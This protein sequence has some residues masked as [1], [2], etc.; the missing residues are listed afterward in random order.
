MFDSY[1]E[2]KER[3]LDVLMSI[4]RS[5]SPINAVAARNGFMVYVEADHPEILP[6]SKTS[7]VDR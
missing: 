3:I 1:S 4:R 5:S 2:L 7:R 6:Q